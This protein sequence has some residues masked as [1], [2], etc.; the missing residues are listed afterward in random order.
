MRGAGVVFVFFETVG[1]GVLLDEDE[2]SDWALAPRLNPTR[3]TGAAIHRRRV[4]LQQR[5]DDL[6]RKDTI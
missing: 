3:R 4:R 1:A 6:I 2:E 5:D